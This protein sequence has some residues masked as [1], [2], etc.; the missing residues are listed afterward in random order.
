MS[1]SEELIKTTVG[2]I[3]KILNT[4][5]VVGEPTTIEGTTIIPLISIGF[6]FGAGAGTGK[7]KDVGEGE[8]GGAG[9]GGGVK[10]VA[11]VVINKDGFHV[12]SIKSGM[13]S[14]ID[15]AVDKAPEMM[16]KMRGKK[17]EEK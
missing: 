1:A 11:V 3:E 17:T 5:T 13:A 8:G 4:K 10:P 2:E 16:D 6:A 7:N 14:V 12:E 9:G 15:K